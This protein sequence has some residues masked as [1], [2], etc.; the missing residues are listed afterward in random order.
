MKDSLPS[1]FIHDF[2]VLEVNAAL[3][4]YQAFAF[5]SYQPSASEV[6]AAL[7]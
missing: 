7:E 2:F 1:F 5:R 3:R 4:S 6:N